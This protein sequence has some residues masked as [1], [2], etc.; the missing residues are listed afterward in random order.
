MKLV[1]KRF[2]IL[3]ILASFLNFV[4][5]NDK[6]VSLNLCTDRLLLEIAKT[7]QIASLS[8]IALDNKL[9]LKKIPKGVLIN[10][11][12]ISELIPF[13]NDVV[14]INKTFYS[15]FYHHLKKLG[16]KVYGYSTPTSKQELITLIKKISK[17]TNNP[18]K[19]EKLISKINNLEKDLTSINK[20]ALVFRVN[21][22]ISN[23]DKSSTGLLL[24]LLG[25][26]NSAKNIK[27]ANNN[28]ISIEKLISIKTDLILQTKYSSDF[29]ISAQISNHPAIQKIISKIPT[30]T[31]PLKYTIC[32]DHGIWLGAKYINNMTF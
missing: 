8:R 2:I 7:E 12:K 18:S 4:F 5:A 27:L 19:G 31:I 28:K 29:S 15:R 24:K 9:L 6:F 13:I 23:D 26:E 11:N 32:F 22:T 16:F 30:L 3:F 1:Y 14:I 25:M 21:T 20:S 17:L 10:N